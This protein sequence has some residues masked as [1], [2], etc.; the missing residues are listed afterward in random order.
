MYPVATNSSTILWK[1]SRSCYLS[2]F[3]S[4]LYSSM[5][6]KG[7]SSKMSGKGSSSKSK[8]GRGSRGTARGGRGGAKSSSSSSGA[9]GLTVV[10]GW[11]Y[12]NYSENSDRYT[13][14]GKGEDGIPEFVDYGPKS[15]R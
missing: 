15:R 5:S 2:P 8:S 7:S 10:S 11:E 14:I 13:Y 6:G 1:Y 12:H 9:S 3:V 4:K